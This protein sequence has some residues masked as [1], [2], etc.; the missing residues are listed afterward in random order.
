MGLFDSI[1]KAIS[2]RKSE[3]RSSLSSRVQA[4]PQDPAA[5]HKLGLFLL[6]QGQVIEGVD[7][8]ARAAVLYEKGGFTGK[9]LAV[10]R[11]MLRH[12]PANLDLIKWLIRLLAQQGHAADAHA[13]LKRVASG[14]VSFPSDD[15][16]FEFFRQ[17]GAHM[18][19]DPFPHFLIAD[20]LIAR[21]KPFEALFELQRAAPLVPAAGAGAEFALRMRQLAPN[22]PESAEFQ[23][24]SG[25]LWLA[26]GSP[27]EAAPLLAS[28]AEG[29]RRAGKGAEASRAERVLAAVNDGTLGAGALVFSF[30]EAARKIER[31]VPPAPGESPREA[32]PAPAG[33]AAAGSPASGTPAPEEERMVRDAVR[34]LRAKVQEEIGQTDPDA[35]YNLGIAY[36]EMG[37]LHEAAEEFR[38][39]RSSPALFLGA[40]ALLAETLFDLGEAE[41]ALGALDEVAADRDAG[42]EANRE[43][44]YRK[45]LLLLRAGRDPEGDEIFLSLY[46]EAPGY[47]DVEDRTRKFRG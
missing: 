11:H 6:K 41:Q 34:R 18:P 39:A 47:R 12:D 16:R 8:L 29:L 17:A 23:E 4:H 31:P 46:E 21:R 28:A 35:R 45:A 9:A 32:E 14:G 22:A 44:R 37:L 1:R 7:Q 27:G 43:A 38:V 13:E 26:A 33:E 15:Q 20:V 25:F 19:G 42:E 3:D 5:R 2:S 24:R 30:E 36:R 40:T 10:L